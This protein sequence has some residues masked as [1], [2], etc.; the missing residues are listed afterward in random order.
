[1]N[2]IYTQ[3]HQN[4][5]HYCYQRLPQLHLR[6]P[7]LHLRNCL[8]SHPLRHRNTPRLCAR[9]LQPHRRRH[10]RSGRRRRR[11]GQVCCR[12][13]CYSCCWRHRGFCLCEI[14][15]AGTASCEQEDPVK[16][17]I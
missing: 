5:H 1:K 7:L 15:G 9:P 13:C 16:C 11:R 8:R 4:G 14:H 10:F 12:Q 3:L 17:Q 2:T 6:A